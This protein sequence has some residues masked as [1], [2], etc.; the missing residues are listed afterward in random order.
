M[1]DED[2]VWMLGLREV[3]CWIR[4]LRPEAVLMGGK[5]LWRAEAT[6]CKG[7]ATSKKDESRGD[8]HASQKA[9]KSR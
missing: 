4:A 1:G 5:R 7:M 9:Q 2:L 6:R 3:V 8:R